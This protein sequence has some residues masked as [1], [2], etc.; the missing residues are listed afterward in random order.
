MAVDV[1]VEKASSSSGTIRGTDYT[2]SFRELVSS[3]EDYIQRRQKW[4]KQRDDALGPILSQDRLTLLKGTEKSSGRG[5]SQKE[6]D[7]LQLRKADEEWIGE[8]RKVVSVT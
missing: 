4:E 1:E 5:I 8:A 3:H 6:R 2:L 7:C